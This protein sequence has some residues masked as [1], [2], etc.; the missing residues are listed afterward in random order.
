MI[1][2]GKDI[3]PSVIVKV[4]NVEQRDVIEIDL[5][6]CTLTKANTG[7]TFKQSDEPIV[8]KGAISLEIPNIHVVTRK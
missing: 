4:D 6:A 5:L 2:F 3:H 8:L 1:I 7:S